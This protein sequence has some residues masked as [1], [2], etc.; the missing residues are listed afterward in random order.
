MRL[1]AAV[2][3]PEPVLLHLERALAGVRPLADGAGV[4]WSS[5]ENLHLTLAFFGDVPDGAVD[6]LGAG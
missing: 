1:F 6:E 4:R 2:R 5:Q 3:P